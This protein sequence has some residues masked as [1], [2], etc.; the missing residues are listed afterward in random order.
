VFVYRFAVEFRALAGAAATKRTR[1]KYRSL[2]P[3][4]ESNE[5]TS[6]PIAVPIITEI[7]LYKFDQWKLPSTSQRAP[8]REGRRGE[9]SRPAA[10]ELG[11]KI[12][13]FREGKEGEREAVPRKKPADEASAAP[14][15]GEEAAAAVGRGGGGAAALVV[16]KEEAALALLCVSPRGVGWRGSGRIDR[17]RR[18]SSLIGVRLLYAGRGPV[19]ALWPKRRSKSF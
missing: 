19:Y 8:E 12:G 15:D 17:G 1:R 13:N 18:E 7:D 3:L 2:H 5:S 16:R 6:A 10:A 11:A 14:S 9:R 4:Q